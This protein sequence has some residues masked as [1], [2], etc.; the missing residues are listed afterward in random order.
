[1]SPLRFFFRIERKIQPN[2]VNMFKKSSITLFLVFLLGS[3]AMAQNGSKL[4]F[5]EPDDV[6]WDNRFGVYGADGI[7][8]DMEYVNKDTIFVS[9]DFKTINGYHTP[10]IAMWNGSYWEAIPGTNN[11]LT[12]G[13]VTHIEYIDGVLYFLSQGRFANFNTETDG[14]LKAYHFDT[15]SFTVFDDQF[16]PDVAAI[17]ATDYGV[18]F[19]LSYTT[20]FGLGPVEFFSALS[21]L[22]N[23]TFFSTISF[24][25]T[26][27][28]PLI[29][30]I[31]EGVVLYNLNAPS[32]YGGGVQLDN[33]QLVF[34]TND[35][36]TPITDF[37]IDT[38]Y[39][40]VYDFDEIEDGIL[41]T[42]T[43]INE[44]CID[45]AVSKFSFSDSTWTNS[46]YFDFGFTTPNKIAG[47]NEHNFTI[48]T[49]NISTFNYDVVKIKNQAAVNSFEIAQASFSP[50]SS[51][52]Q[53]GD[54][55][56]LSFPNI[57]INS[58]E[59]ISD[60]ALFDEEVKQL[61]SNPNALG[62][63]GKVFTMLEAGNKIYAG[64][65]FS[66]AG[67]ELIQS[68]AVFENDKWNSIGSFSGGNLSTSVIA[69]NAF[70]KY[71]FV[72]GSF[73]RITTENETYYIHNLAI[74]DTTNGE[75]SSL[76]FSGIVSALGVEKIGNRLYAFGRHQVSLSTQLYEYKDGFWSTNIDLGSNYTL[77]TSGVSDIVSVDNKLF[78]AGNLTVR[79][80]SNPEETEEYSILVIEPSGVYPI[81]LPAYFDEETFLPIRFSEID[82]EILISTPNVL[83]ASETGG[84]D[85][86]SIY[87]ITQ[88]TVEA[89][90]PSPGGSQV[91]LIGSNDRLFAYS[92]TESGAAGFN[93][94]ATWDGEAWNILGNGVRST[95]SVARVNAALITSD[96]RLAVGGSFTFAGNKPASNF[97]F[98]SGE[99]APSTP[100]TISFKNTPVIAYAE[101]LTFQW[102]N[103]NFSSQFEFE[104]SD[105]ENFSNLIVGIT[106]ISENRVKVRSSFDSGVIYYWRVRAVNSTGVSDWSDV[107]TFEMAAT[108][109]AEKNE[110][111]VQFE[112]MQNYPN[113]FNPSTSIQFSIPATQ[114]VT[115][116]VF[117]IS[118]RNVATLV[119]GQTLSA[120]VHSISFEASQLASGVYFYR[121]QSGKN[122]Q[123]KKMLLIK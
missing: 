40:S 54:T 25:N 26:N 1:M 77:E 98:W 18:L 22:E 59:P 108:V 70:D 47:K 106:G 2:S 19:V 84:F 69:L 86:S 38:T 115:L 24:T 117:D 37:G 43:S 79:S 14:K 123:S 31:G 3:I 9:G 30:A 83:S 87:K 91:S 101:E 55:T 20:S 72:S 92:A 10:G 11:D 34:A 75:W 111:V 52:I 68:L 96:G 78:I 67:N 57:S 53:I 62:L 13:S 49:R 120:G 27:L 65:T 119:N 35:Y 121:I 8:R 12:I 29:K 102:T 94:I 42:G 39:S 85:A 103:S 32:I 107:G 15:E 110:A 48:G 73:D 64:G 104:L 61:G 93:G 109:S 81:H 28:A 60:F 71:L 41:F 118:G 88:D 74:Y 63:S 16:S 6:F 51:M 5:D 46:Y 95:N 36:S 89:F 45:C 4:K 105:T 114:K 99:T 116:Q 80:T 90:L 21:Y 113:P 66:A 50:I 122:V 97:T 100:V 33:P 7:V 76:E 44:G 17:E 56:I 82:G 58:S 112:L 23:D